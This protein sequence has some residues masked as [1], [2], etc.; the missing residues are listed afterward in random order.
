MSHDRINLTHVSIFVQ[1]DDV[2][3]IDARDDC[4]ELVGFDHT[5]KSNP[6]AN[7]YVDRSE[8]PDPESLPL[9]YD[10]AD[11]DLVASSENGRNVVVGGEIEKTNQST[12]SGT[13]CLKFKVIPE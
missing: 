8:L 4:D 13:K 6:Y 11:F 7:V 5:D 2:E 3:V 1:D 9:G 10:Y 12:R